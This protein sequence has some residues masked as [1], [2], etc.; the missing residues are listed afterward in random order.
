MVNRRNDWQIEVGIMQKEMERFLGRFAQCT[1]PLAQ[2]SSGVWQPLV[3]IYETA[4]DLVILI[5]S[6]GVS[7]E[8]IKLSLLGRTL[9]IRGVRPDHLRGIRRAFHLMEIS[10]GPFE[11]SLELP[12]AVDVERVRTSCH[13]GFLEVVFPKSTRGQAQAVV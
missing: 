10:F 2:S 1:S 12:V 5:D 13:D 8:Q 3:D 4:E 7:C 11:R 9:T 6:A